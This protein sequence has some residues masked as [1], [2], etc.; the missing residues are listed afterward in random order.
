[1]L[2]LHIYVAAQVSIP[3]SLMYYFDIDWLSFCITHNLITPSY[4][5]LVAAICQW[6]KDDWIWYDWQIAKYLLIIQLSNPSTKLFIVY[7]FVH[8]EMLNI[9]WIVFANPAKV[10]YSWARTINW[11]AVT[12]MPFRYVRV[13]FVLWIWKLRSS[14]FRHWPSQ[15]IFLI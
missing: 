15:N 6:I 12:L 14:V 8:E 5:H 9:L 4:F 1:M 7:L 10:E 11:P 2:F 3:K 13:R